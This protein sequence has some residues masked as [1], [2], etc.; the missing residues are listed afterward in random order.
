MKAVAVPYV[1]A[2]VLGI[3]VIGLIGY[4]LIASAGGIDKVRC[5]LAKKSLCSEWYSADPAYASGKQPPKPATWP[6]DENICSYAKLNKPGGD[7]CKE[8]IGKG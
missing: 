6:A 2:I 5:D 4:L 8:L 1:I 7:Q 3:A